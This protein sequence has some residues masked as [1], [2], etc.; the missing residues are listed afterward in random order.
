MKFWSLHDPAFSLIDGTVDHSLSEFYTS[1]KGVKDAYHKL[2]TRIG[3]P[4]GQ[5]VWCYTVNDHIPRT[6]IA[7]VL[8][9]LDIP[10]DRILCFVDDIAWNKIIGQNQVA[11]PRHL[12]HE[13]D[14][15]PKTGNWWDELVVSD[16]VPGLLTTALI[17]HPVPETYVRTRLD[18]KV[19][20]QKPKHSRGLPRY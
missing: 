5:I 1:V 20:R 9:C 17:Q 12:R 11:L 2:W 19:E 15:Q 8:W 10:D 13:W 7:K 4:D 14:R 16:N 3:R 18:W 6:G